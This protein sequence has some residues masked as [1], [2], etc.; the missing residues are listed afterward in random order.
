MPGFFGKLLGKDAESKVQSIGYLGNMKDDASRAKLI[1][2][3]SDE[4]VEVRRAAATALEQHFTSGSVEAI[5]A[6]T[7]AL[8]DPD[9][10]VRKNAVR[11]LGGFI[12]K[13]PDAGESGKAKQAIISLIRR[14]T[15]EG[16][17]KNAV[18][19]LANVQDQALMGPIADAFRGKDKK[20]IT[21]AI[22]AINDLPPTD[23]RMEMKKALRSVL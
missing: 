18:I 4:S 7:K 15:D 12:S 8:D 14:E 20:A 21:M 22:D 10:I 6:L 9:A 5:R 13:S 3:L 2:F 11:S 19:G 23:A 16:V 1:K 17:L